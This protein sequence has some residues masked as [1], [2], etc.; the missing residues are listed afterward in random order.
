MILAS[1][2]G[3]M[4]VLVGIFVQKA[5][6]IESWDRELALDFTEMEHNNRLQTYEQLFKRIDKDSSGCISLEELKEKLAG[7]DADCERIQ[8]YFRHLGIDID[9]EAH[10]ILTA[11]DVNADGVLSLDEFK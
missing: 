10:D 2:F 1:L 3:I 5:G 4:N 6:Q 11:L 9:S 8:T 7:S